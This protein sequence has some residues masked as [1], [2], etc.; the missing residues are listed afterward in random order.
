MNVYDWDRT[1]YRKDTTAAFYLWCLRRYPRIA[2][3]WP[4]LIAALVRWRT[5]RCDKTAFKQVLL[6]FL[7][8][9]PDPQR[10]IERFWDREI[11]KN[12][13]SWFLSQQAVEDDLVITASPRCFVEP[14]CRRIGIKNLIGSPVDIATGRYH[15]VNCDGKNKVSAFDEAYP[16]VVPEAFYSDSLNDA[17]MARLA[18][19]AYRVKGERVRAWPDK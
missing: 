6:S 15:G 14:A 1:I 13:H 8:D 12:I 10:E 19:K 2:R 5:G 4:A 11:L 7:S 17:P 18:R 3:R 9:V 16:G